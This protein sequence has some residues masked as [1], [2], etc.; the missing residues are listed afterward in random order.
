[1][2][3]ACGSENCPVER[4]LVVWHDNYLDIRCFSVLYSDQ[5]SEVENWSKYEAFRGPFK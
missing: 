5:T 3:L 4:T 2:G 1:M